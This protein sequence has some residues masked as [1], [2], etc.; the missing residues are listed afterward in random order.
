MK[1]HTVNLGLPVDKYGSLRHRHGGCVADSTRW[2]RSEANCRN[3]RIIYF[4]Q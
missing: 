2:S 4:N 3:K 1:I